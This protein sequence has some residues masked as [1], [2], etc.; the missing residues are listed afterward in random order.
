VS[1][2]GLLESSS[3]EKKYMYPK[4]GNST[5]T[6]I[7]KHK[8]RKVLFSSMTW[9]KAIPGNENIRKIHTIL[10]RC[11]VCSYCLS[12]ALYLDV[13]ATLYPNVLKC[14][15]SNTIALF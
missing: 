5:A 9:M 1:C 10:H 7:S 12:S 15:E 11:L 4:A 8:N 14:V 2:S 3:F 13:P 6:A